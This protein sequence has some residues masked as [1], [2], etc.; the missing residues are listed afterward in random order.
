[1]G[2]PD[3]W[4][5]LAVAHLVFNFFEGI[6]KTSI[7][8]SVILQGTKVRRIPSGTPAIGVEGKNESEFTIFPTFYF[9]IYKT[10]QS[11]PFKF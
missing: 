4:A 5:G 10:D 1:M 6:N 3:A 8:G 2:H 11:D 9:Y 7:A